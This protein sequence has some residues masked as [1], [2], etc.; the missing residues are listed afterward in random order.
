MPVDSARRDSDGALGFD[1]FATRVL[2]VVTFGLGAVCTAQ[3]D[4]WWLLRA[5]RDIWRTGHVPLADHYSYTA[6]GRYWPNH[7]WLWEAVAYALHHVG[8]MPLLAAWTGA[9]VAG[10]AWVMRHNSRAEG[11]VVPLVLGLALPLMSVVWTIRPQVTSMLLFAV[12]MRLVARE[13]YLWIP[14]LFLLWANLHAQVGMGGVLLAAVL[15]VALVDLGRSATATARKRTLLL[16]S[17]TVAGAVATLATPLG[18]KLWGYVLDARGRAAQDGIAE[19][20][21]TFHSATGAA[22]LFPVLLVTVVLGVRRRG[23]LATWSERVPAIAALATAPLAILA[24]RN[25]P[26]FLVAAVPLLMTLLEFRTT[27]PV[28]TVRRWRAAL[29]AFVLATAAVTALVWVVQPAKLAWRPVPSGMATALRACPGPLY[30]RYDDGAALLWFVPDVKV[31]SDNRFDPYPSSVIDASMV[32]APGDYRRTFDRFGIRC[33]LL[34]RRSALAA[35]VLRDGWTPT[36][37][38]GTSVVLVPPAT[39]RATSATE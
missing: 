36:Y 39:P 33:A 7:E 20:T 14:P 24:V 6:D 16:A 29:C 5:G 28:G 30:N 12:T 27:Q 10:T 21:A 17:S 22:I 37:D 3:A 32:L 23:R 4:L 11:Y 25:I 34:H 35:A 38:D 19:W 31:F 8:G 26:F 9:V 2:Y 18:P 1:V 13:R 15:V